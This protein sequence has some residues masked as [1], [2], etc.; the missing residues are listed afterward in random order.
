MVKSGPRP[1]GALFTMEPE[2]ETKV[3]PVGHADAT[4][5]ASADPIAARRSIGRYE[6]VQRL[7][8]GGMATVYLGRA[9]G[10]AGFE[11]LVAIKVIHPHLAA[12]PEFVEMFLEEAR[13]A[14]KIQS[15]H[16]AGILDLGQDE[17]L[18]YMVMEYIDGETLSGLIRQLRPRA[19]HLPLTVVLQILVDACEGLTAVHDLRDPDGQPYGLVHRDMSPQNLMVGFDGW[20]KIVDFGLVKATGKRHTHTGHLRGKLAYMSPEQA[21][22]KPLTASADLFALGVVLWELLTG[23]R[24]FAGESDAETLDRVVRCE[25]PALAEQRADLP[26]DIEPILRRALARD[27]A[28]RYATADAM[29]VDLRRCLLA[30]LGDDDP[31]KELAAIMRLHFDEQAKYR[32]AA[33][34]GGSRSHSRPRMHIV[35]RPPTGSQSALEEG[36]RSEP[37]LALVP[38][39]ATPATP[40][41]DEEATVP[42]RPPSDPHERVPSGVRAPSGSAPALGGLADEGAARTLTAGPGR[43]WGWWL[44]LPMLGAALAVAILLAVYSWRDQSGPV[45]DAQRGAPANVVPPGPQRDLPAQ[46]RRIVWNFES[47]PAGAQ[48]SIS[49]TPPAVAADIEA[50]LAGRLTPFSI[51]IPYDEKTRIEVLFTRPGYKVSRRSLLPISSENIN[52]SLQLEASGVPDPV[53]KRKPPTKHIGPTKL[54]TPKPVGPVA[55]ATTAGDE[56]KDEPTFGPPKDRGSP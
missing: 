45:T 1:G 29:L 23:K 18:Y 19:Q 52:V 9:T 44:G 21:R 15:P 31:R 53:T 8:H 7:G 12:E 39:V 41:P 38:N 10:S 24:L 2:P 34:R 36:T 32:S 6:I 33:L 35:P 51:E 54:S 49:G 25:L 13:I 46:P 37:A 30:H 26:P 14:A 3:L 48:V 20:I 17:G 5:I 47:D 40:M 42:H 28:D 55:P 11:K 50:Q 16:V 43:H 56:L 27:P 22:G 4:P